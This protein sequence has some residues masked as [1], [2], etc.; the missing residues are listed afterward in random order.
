MAATRF[1]LAGLRSLWRIQAGVCGFTFAATLFDKR[2]A[3][4][5]GT[6]SSTMLKCA[7]GWCITPCAPRHRVN[8]GS[9]LTLCTGR[10]HRLAASVK[11]D[12]PQEASL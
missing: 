12:A 10:A 3:T 4:P 11:L 7:F 6:S 2:L 5:A 8:E 9:P 1:A